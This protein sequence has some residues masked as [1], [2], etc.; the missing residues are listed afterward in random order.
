MGHLL[1][2]RQ[3]RL[4]V[5]LSGGLKASHAFQGRRLDDNLIRRHFL[6]VVGVGAAVAAEVAFHVVAALAI[7]DVF[8][9]GVFAFGDL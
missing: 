8:L 5:D 2:P 4:A 9:E 1:D 3:P 7:V 6:P